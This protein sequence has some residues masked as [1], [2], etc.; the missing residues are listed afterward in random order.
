MQKLTARAQRNPAHHPAFPRPVVRDRNPAHAHTPHTRGTRRSH[1]HRVHTHAPNRAHEP[2]H[3]TC[4]RSALGANWP[5]HFAA[6]PFTD[7]SMLDAWLPLLH[8]SC[9]ALR[10]AHPAPL[11]DLTRQSGFGARFWSRIAPLSSLCARA[12]PGSPQVT[13]RS[14]FSTWNSAPLA[15]CFAPDTLAS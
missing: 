2:G 7:Y 5:P 6:A 13:D 10:F 12:G 1:M 9:P 11:A 14:V 3:W 8:A 4:P 15:N